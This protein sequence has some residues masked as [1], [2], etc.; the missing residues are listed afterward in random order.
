MKSLLP[1]L[2]ALA[3]LPSLAN[4]QQML[5]IYCEEC[6]DLTQHPEDARN[7]SYNQVF[8]TVQWLSMDQADRFQITDGFGNT[9]TID[10][11]V[12]YR[13]SNLARLLELRSFD[14]GALGRLLV[15]SMLIQIRVIYPNLDIVTYV[16]TR[17][18]VSGDLPVG[19]VLVHIDQTHLPHNAAGLQCKA[20]TGTH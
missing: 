7:F 14:L 12:D 18:D 10:I 8:G 3:T 1:I 16:F 4:A 11:N 9:V 15:N 2:F 13:S 5:N 20:R 6:R 17:E 19:E